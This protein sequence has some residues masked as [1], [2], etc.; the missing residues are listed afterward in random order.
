[1]RSS[2]ARCGHISPKS[3]LGRLD[4]VTVPGHLL[5]KIYTSIKFKVSG[6]TSYCGVLYKRHHSKDNIKSTSSCELILHSTFSSCSQVFDDKM[7]QS[8]HFI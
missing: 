7:D 8:D 4:R 1:M 3:V 6:F 2:T 5:L